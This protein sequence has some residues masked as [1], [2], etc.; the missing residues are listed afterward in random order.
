[1]IDIDARSNATNKQTNPERNTHDHGRNKSRP[2][3]QIGAATQNANLF[4]LLLGLFGA[5]PRHLASRFDGRQRFARQFD[6]HRRQ[7]AI[8]GGDGGVLLILL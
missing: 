6:L 7:E 2:V 8:G 5:Q 4:D 3:Y 1:M